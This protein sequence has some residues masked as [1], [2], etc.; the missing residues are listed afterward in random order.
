MRKILSYG[1]LKIFCKTQD[2]RQRDY[3]T[4]SSIL[5]PFL[6]ELIGLTLYYCSSSVSGTPIPNHLLTHCCFAFRNFAL[7]FVNM[8]AN[9]E[10]TSEGRCSSTGTQ[11]SRITLGKHGVYINFDCIRCW[12][13]WDALKEGSYIIMWFKTF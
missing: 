6:V 11:T 10:R 7:Q 12:F 13:F 1:V 4:F 3:K 5:I 2:P 8:H 9:N